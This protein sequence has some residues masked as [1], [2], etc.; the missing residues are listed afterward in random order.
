MSSGDRSWGD[1]GYYYYSKY[2]VRTFGLRCFF[3]DITREELN[4]I[5]LWLSKDSCGKLIFDDRK[6][7]YYMVRPAGVTD[8][9]PFG[10]RH[11]WMNQMTYSGTFTCQMTAYDPL[12]VMNISSTE[13]GAMT[14]DYSYCGILPSSMMPPEPVTTDTSFLI[15]NCGTNRCEPVI[16]LAGSAPSG[17]TI[18]NLSN[19]TTCTLVALPEEGTVRIDG[20]IGK[21]T[22]VTEGGEE[23]AFELHDDGYISLESYGVI[24][25]DVIVQT[26]AGSNLLT[27]T[28]FIPTTQ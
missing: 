14:E 23:E 10:V 2:K 15:Y 12:G 21:V 13:D 27:V 22:V 8:L 1:G 9:E 28:G 4:Q 7:V 5:I 26:T 3:E 19:G 17:V 18:R 24:F 25:R 6:D 11:G 20:A 16:E